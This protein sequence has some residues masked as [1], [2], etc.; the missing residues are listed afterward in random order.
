MIFGTFDVF[1]PGHQFFIE[2]AKKESD[3]LIVI[4]ARDKTVKKIK[5]E[6]KNGER[7]RLKVLQEHF[8]TLSVLLGD[9]KNPLKV[10][11]EYRP[12]KVCLGYDQVGFSEELQKKFPEIVIKRLPAFFPEKYKSSKMNAMM[13]TS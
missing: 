3:E 11:E 5:P 7:I 1:H 9:E 13:K 8:P 10:F 12:E 6:L 4:V 2:T